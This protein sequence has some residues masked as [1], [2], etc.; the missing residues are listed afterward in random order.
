[1]KRTYADLWVYL[2]VIL[3][4]ALYWATGWKAAAAPPRPFLPGLA[5]ALILGVNAVFLYLTNDRVVNEM[6]L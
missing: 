6:S 4:V 5:A 1:M 2:A 3:L